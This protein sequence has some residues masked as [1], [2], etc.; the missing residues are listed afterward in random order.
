[1]RHGWLSRLWAFININKRFGGNI[2]GPGLEVG[3]SEGGSSREGAAQD[4]ER[5]VARDPGR[6]RICHGSGRSVRT[7]GIPGLRGRRPPGLRP[8]PLH[9]RHGDRQCEHAAPCTAVHP[10][11]PLFHGKSTSDIAPSPPSH[12]ATPP[13]S[14]GR[15]ESGAR[16]PSFSPRSLSSPWCPSSMPST[17]F[18]S[19]P[20]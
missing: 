10:V 13:G 17:T 7:H 12:G 18:C 3:E 15:K 8:A 1:M 4:G 11:H 6:R 14:G 2:F 20:R 5:L 16:L 9:G 19:S